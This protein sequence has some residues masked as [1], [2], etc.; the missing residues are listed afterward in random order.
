MDVNL[1]SSIFIVSSDQLAMM[2]PVAFKVV[3]KLSSCPELSPAVHLRTR[4]YII[5]P[6]S[7]DS[8]KCQ[9][10]FSSPISVKLVYIMLAPHLLLISLFKTLSNI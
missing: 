10:R 8:R 3:S 5:F 4:I 2:L 9:S 1:I 6:T 7:R